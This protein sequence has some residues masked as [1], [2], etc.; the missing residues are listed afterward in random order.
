MK[1]IIIYWSGTG[2]TLSMAERLKNDLGCEAIDC[3]NANGV[4]LSQYDN[5]ILG[6]PAMGDEEL[7]DSSFR[8][9]YENALASTVT[10]FA[11]FGSYGW[12]SG[13]WMEKWKDET[14]QNGKNVLAT[15]IFNGDE[16]ACDDADYSNF[17]ASLN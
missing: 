2:N 17:V 15:L 11:L 16:S 14:E 5:I 10:N 7:E 1:N 8:P 13:D 6:C 3:D 4:D 9:F 12:G